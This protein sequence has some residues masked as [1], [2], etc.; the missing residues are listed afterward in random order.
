MILKA[1]PMPP[2]SPR[3]DAHHIVNFSDELNAV[4]PA[5]FPISE[6]SSF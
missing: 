3:R 2:G 5:A 4:L 6:F 1:H